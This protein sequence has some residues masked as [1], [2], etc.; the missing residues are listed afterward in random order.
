MRHD[1]LLPVPPQDPGGAL[2]AD[3]TVLGALTVRRIRSVR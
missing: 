3:G 2:G 1:P